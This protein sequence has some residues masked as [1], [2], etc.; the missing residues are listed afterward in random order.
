MSIF[1]SKHLSINTFRFHLYKRIKAGECYKS[2][3]I[4]ILKKKIISVQKCEKL[5]QI[6]N[7]VTTCI[8]IISKQNI[9]YAMYAVY[10]L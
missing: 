8:F 9:M 2:K 10:L 5:I 3:R 4:C 7:L 6:A 1:L